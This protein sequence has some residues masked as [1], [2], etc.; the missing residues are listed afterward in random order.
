MRWIATLLAL[1]VGAWFFSN[2]RRKAQLQERVQ[3]FM[4][5]AMQDQMRNAAATVTEAA[6][7]A[8]SAVQPTA[9]KAREA[10]Q[11]LAS[12]AQETVQNAAASAQQATGG[13]QNP[14]G[15]GAD[16]ETDVDA[17][18]PSVKE[19]VQAELA[20]VGEKVDAIRSG[21]EAAPDAAE[22]SAGKSF[23]EGTVNATELRTAAAP[24]S[25]REAATATAPPTS[26][27]GS[28]ESSPGGSSARPIAGEGT[29]TAGGGTVNALSATPAG[30]ASTAAGEPLPEGLTPGEPGT[31]GPRGSSVAPSTPGAASPTT[32]M[33]QPPE[34]DRTE[35]VL[36]RTSGDFIGNKK[37]RVFHAATAGNLPGEDNRV[38]FESEEEAVAA[39]FR[40]AEREGLDS[41]ES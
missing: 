7:N 37:T 26:E 34:I 5:P 4:P 39:G 25:T 9:D 27:G 40:P 23:G 24:Q 16:V 29:T 41:A 18:P 20:D 33:E 8:A 31:G 14:S 36:E 6:K 22:K 12:A 32:G 28:G 13:S 17:A 11:N 38:Y 1:A 10:A 21:S 15:A 30:G 2:R 19:T 3:D 35:E